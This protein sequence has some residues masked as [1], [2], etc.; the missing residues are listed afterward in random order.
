M[1]TALGAAVFLEPVLGIT[2][3]VVWIAIALAW[4]TAS[5]ASLVAMGLYVPGFAILGVRG[6]SLAWSAAIAALV[7]VRH[8]PNIRRLVAGSEQS[9]TPG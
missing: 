9:V 5:I 4:K 1:A 2:L 3:L 6:A 7:L 8:A